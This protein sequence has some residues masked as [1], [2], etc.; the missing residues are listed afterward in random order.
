[1]NDTHRPARRRH[2]GRTG[3]VAAGTAVLAVAGT[4]AAAA[5][6]AP[7]SAPPDSSAPAPMT[8]PCDTVF[9]AGP[10]DSMAP[11]ESMAAAGSMAPADSTAMGSMAPAESMAP[12]AGPFVQTAVT[13]YGTVLVDAGCRAVYA[14]L[15]D[16]EGEPTCTD[17]CAATWPPLVV[18]DDAVP[19][20][21]TGL[22]PA[23]FSV[24]EHPTDGP[25]LKA[26]DW[27]LYL[28]ASDVAPGDLNGQGVGDV[29]WL[30]G[31]D[32]TP[33]TGA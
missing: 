14:F 7:P 31:P 22:D 33:I 1:M 19:E 25:M 32:G 21:A 11:V 23:L 18:P 10:A 28:F 17:R 15:T 29:W 8:S 26:G 9:A 24:V 16:T 12:G 13:E 3:W 2:R 20:V 6:S 30:V 27:P 5:A 4:A